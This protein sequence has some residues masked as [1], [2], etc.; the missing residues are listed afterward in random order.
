[1]L[2]V[3]TKF[4]QLFVTC[5]CM[6]IR[7]AHL[8]CPYHG[9]S[10]RHSPLKTSQESENLSR[11]RRRRWRTN[12]AMESVH[13]YSLLPFGEGSH[14]LSMRKFCFDRVQESRANY[15]HTR[16]EQTMLVINYIVVRA[17]CRCTRR[18]WR[19][20]HRYDL[21]CCSQPLV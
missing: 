16:K 6:F 19:C 15:S 4:K 1:M 8:R 14:F 2:D 5:T 10:R 12:L 17:V 21:L 20:I 3:N 9:A 13:I 11:E 7:T 18:H